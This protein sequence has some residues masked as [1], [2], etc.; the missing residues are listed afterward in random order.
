[1]KREGEEEGMLEVV[2]AQSIEDITKP[3][4]EQGRS[5]GLDEINMQT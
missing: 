4:R 5:N 3:A 1:M 2:F